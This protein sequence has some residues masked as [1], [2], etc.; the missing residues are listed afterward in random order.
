VEGSGARPL[1]VVLVGDRGSEERHDAVAGE[2]VDRT[3]EA[4]HA[5]PEQ[6]VE[7]ARQVAPFLGVHTG[8]EIH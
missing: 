1:R 8:G 7:P 2:L 4:R 3:V 6:F 5:V